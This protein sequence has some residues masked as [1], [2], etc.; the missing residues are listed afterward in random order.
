MPLL[1]AEATLYGLSKDRSIRH[2]QLS[3]GLFAVVFV[4]GWGVNLSFGYLFESWPLR[5]GVYPRIILGAVAI[6]AA[7]ILR[8]LLFGL[9][10][11]GLVLSLL[12]A[13]RNRAL[14][15]SLALGIA[16]IVGYLTGEI[17]YYRT[18]DI[19]SPLFVGSSLGVSVGLLGFLLGSGLR[20]TS[21]RLIGR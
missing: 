9:I 3:Y 2:L 4:V 20:V 11:C 10:A 12:S 8:W 21:H 13:Y 14:L 1:D 17:V 5:N 18:W 6:P 16:P 15:A 19:L 7:D